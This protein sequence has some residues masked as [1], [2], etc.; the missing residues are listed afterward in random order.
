MSEANDR[1]NEIIRKYEGHDSKLVSQSTHMLN[2]ACIDL[3]V[4]AENMHRSLKMNRM[5]INEIISLLAQSQKEHWENVSK[6]ELKQI[7]AVSVL[8][9]LTTEIA[10]G[11]NNERDSD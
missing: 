6:D 1:I 3:F 4:I 9:R 7:T 2:D 5:D 8:S 11:S 10:R